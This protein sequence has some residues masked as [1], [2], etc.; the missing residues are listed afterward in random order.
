MVF[1]HS[2]DAEY[3]AIQP[4][5]IVSATAGDVYDARREADL[6]GNQSW[7]EE[8]AIVDELETMREALSSEYDYDI[9][10]DRASLQSWLNGNISNVRSMMETGVD[11]SMMLFDLPGFDRMTQMLDRAATENPGKFS[12]LQQIR[13]KVAKKAREKW[14][15]ANAVAARAHGFD[16]FLGEAGAGIVRDINEPAL[17]MGAIATAPIAAE[18]FGASLFA[19]GLGIAATEGIAAG[20]SEATVSAGLIDFWERQGFTNPEINE[21][22]LSNVGSAAVGASVLSPAFY[23]GGVLTKAAAGRWAQMV[24]SKFPEQVAEAA[25][26]MQQAGV[27]FTSR[28]QADIATLLQRLEEVEQM[29]P[30]LSSK[31]SGDIGVYQQNV[32]ATMRALE[33][34]IVPDE[35]PARLAFT[36]IPKMEQAINQL[37]S[38]AKAP[39]RAQMQAMLMPDEFDQY[40]LRLKGA[41]ELNE[42]QSQ[43]PDIGAYTREKGVYKNV[44]GNQDVKIEKDGR[45]W[46]PSINE[47]RIPDVEPARTLAEAKEQVAQIVEGQKIPKKTNQQ[48]AREVGLEQ[49]RDGLRRRQGGPVVRANIT[50]ATIL[51]TID[52]QVSP[53]SLANSKVDTDP[54][55]KYTSMG[56]PDGKAQIGAVPEDPQISARIDEGEF[57]STLYKEAMEAVEGYRGR[58]PEESDLYSKLDTELTDIEGKIADAKDVEKA[59]DQPDVAAMESRMQELDAK[60]ELSPDEKIELGDLQEQ[61]FEAENAPPVLKPD[62]KK[63]EAQAKSIRA[64][65][66]DLD[67]KVAERQMEHPFASDTELQQRLD[68][69]R[70][71]EEEEADLEGLLECVIRNSA[72]G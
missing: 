19:R 57:D 34:G 72:S 70:E 32:T 14:E 46:V 51:D 38:G 36:A 69:I 41:R 39:T 13:D 47:E 23:L 22:L 20:I 56:G 52:A 24:A 45:R 48:I 18:Y 60:D 65:M 7:S 28:E 49:L 59:V 35:L 17:V 25:A 29:P 21:K 30:F 2:S 55:L 33:T 58:T 9:D 50:D 54:V 44:I 40:N 26:E 68:E 16:R 11:E 37:Q 53:E 64:Q 61:L 6:L 62:T 42:V 8:D 3:A 4:F 67:K 15:A 31:N 66:D 1:V 43:V 27:K 10:I 5:G 12:T 71:L 63:M